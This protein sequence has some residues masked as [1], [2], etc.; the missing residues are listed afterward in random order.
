MIPKHQSASVPNN[1]KHKN[2]GKTNK[3]TT[4]QPEE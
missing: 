4:S 2:Q 1:T 3:N